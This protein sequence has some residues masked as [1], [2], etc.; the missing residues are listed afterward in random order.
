MNPEPIVVYPIR[1]KGGSRWANNELRY[2]LRSLD[3]F[4]RLNSGARPRVFILSTATLPFLEGNLTVLP[5]QSYTE[6][7]RKAGELAREH[8]P[9]GDYVWMNDDVAFLAEATP[10]DLLPALYTGPADTQSVEAETPRT[11]W[12]EKLLRIR[13]RLVEMGLTPLNFST[14]T[15]YLFNAD[16]MDIVC[17]VFGLMYKTPLET[18]Y[19]NYWSDRIPSRR[20]AGE[21]LV[22]YNMAEPLPLD[23]RGKKYLT[24]AD[25]GLDDTLKGFLHGLFPTPSFYERC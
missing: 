1:E 17:G 19:F 15:P 8:S 25:A 20:C 13:D 10:A 16:L 21:R 23:L 24:Y 9:T 22:R 12:R 11:G 18:A 4:F 3:R 5:I 2:S 14:H 7:V 6:A